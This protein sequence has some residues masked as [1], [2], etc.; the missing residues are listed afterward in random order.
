MNFYLCT[1]E[2]I[3]AYCITAWY[4]SCTR[5]DQ[6]A[7][8]SVIKVAQ[9]IIGTQLLAVGDICQARCQGRASSIICDPAWPAHHLFQL[10]PSGRQYREI[11]PHTSRLKTSFFPKAVKFFEHGLTVLR[12]TH[13]PPTHP[14][15]HTHTGAETECRKTEQKFCS[16]AVLQT[17]TIKFI[18]S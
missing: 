11:H 16:V 7:M 13:T 2:S 1:V 12:H 4:V 5:K 10:L 18:M 17:M 14:L 15:Q 6:K 8:H 3:L 9:N